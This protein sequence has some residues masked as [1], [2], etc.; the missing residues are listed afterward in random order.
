MT[1]TLLNSERFKRYPIV[2]ND[3]LQAWDSAD[4]LLLKHLSTFDLSNKRILIIN[5]SFGALTVSL[6]NFDVSSYTD[7][8]VSYR[9]I[10]Q[11]GAFESL[12]FSDL[13]QVNGTYDYVLIK[14]P[15]VMSFFED[16]LCRLT[17]HI[18]SETQFVCAGM[19][20][21]MA[22]SSFDLLNKYIGETSTGLAE[23]KARLIFAQFEKKA[24]SSPYPKEQ[25]LDGLPIPF[26]NGSNLFSR[27][28]LDVG[29]RFFLQHLPKGDFQNVLD[30]GCANGVVGIKFKDLNPESKI[31]FSDDSYMAILSAREN[32]KK[33]F[34]DDASFDWTNCYEDGESNSFD[35]VLCNPPFHQSNTIGDFI[36]WQM[37]VD[38]KRILKNGGLIR[39]VGNSHLR[40]QQKLK[41]I[42][43]NSEIIA[44]NKKFM[45]VDAY[46]R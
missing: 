24:V 39:I 28:K 35:L 12:L 6:K 3:K 34:D 18:N 17:S 19:I 10:L 7:S 32:Y 4:Q 27:E 38:A 43:G 14:L 9:G 41:K 22:K 23:K 42:F 37:F 25:K 5:D 8:Y 40:Y 21:H 45:I 46:K 31:I 29:T 33:Y 30:L 36:A 16:I 11:N 20:K 13:S 26:S 44:T 15:K 2:K 1:I